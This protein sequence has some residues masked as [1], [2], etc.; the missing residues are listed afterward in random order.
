[1]PFKD[2]SW[3]LLDVLKCIIHAESKVAMDVY[4]SMI[5]DEIKHQTIEFMTLKNPITGI[6]KLFNL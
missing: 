3:S 4:F 2:G 5:T 6:Y 1:M